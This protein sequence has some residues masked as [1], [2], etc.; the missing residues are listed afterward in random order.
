MGKGILS[1]RRVLFGAGGVL[2]TAAVVAVVKNSRSKEA[3]SE[4]HLLEPDILEETSRVSVVKA[5][6][7]TS[8]VTARVKLAK[9]QLDIVEKKTEAVYVTSE[10]DETEFYDRVQKA[11]PEERQRLFAE[12]HSSLIN[13]RKIL[14]EPE[15]TE[16]L[17]RK[18]RLE[19]I[20]KLEMMLQAVQDTTKNTVSQKEA[21]GFKQLA[22]TF[23]MNAMELADE[24][25]TAQWDNIQKEYEEICD[26]T[27]NR[28][29]SFSSKVMSL[30]SRIKIGQG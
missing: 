17:G 4:D 11:A 21:E 10:A 12:R 24:I 2:A 7:P 18:Q 15:F 3:G 5:S 28:F 9:E 6:D 26:L 16:M 1:N 30:S 25:F 23:A 19:K 8:V 14:N 13:A 27:K 29:H 20:T 22:A